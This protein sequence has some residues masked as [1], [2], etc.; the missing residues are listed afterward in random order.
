M[1][2]KPC[3]RCSE[4]FVP[5]RFATTRFCSHKCQAAQYYQDN[6]ER[7]AQRD[8]QRSAQYRLDNKERIAQRDVQYRLER[9]AE[10]PWYWR[11]KARAKRRRQLKRQ[12][13]AAA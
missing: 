10:D 7:I 6:K 1:D 13:E 4:M 8:V 11:K 2:P 9:L 5:V 3:E 12:Q